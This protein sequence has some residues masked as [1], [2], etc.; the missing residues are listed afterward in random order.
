MQIIKYSP[1]SIQQAVIMISV[2]W[3]KME[4]YPMPEL[5]CPAIELALINLFGLTK[6]FSYLF[7]LFMVSFVLLSK[8]QNGLL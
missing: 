7:M 1:L 3:A 5:F 4:G 6:V 2:F 8:L